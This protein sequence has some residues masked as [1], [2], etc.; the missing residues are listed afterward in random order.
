MMMMMEE[1]EERKKEK[2]IESVLVPGPSGGLD[3]L[4]FLVDRQRI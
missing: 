4:V 1:K 2:S 3:S